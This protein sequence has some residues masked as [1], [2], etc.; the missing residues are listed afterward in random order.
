M[1]ITEIKL[2]NFRNYDEEIIELNKGINIFYGN[3]AQGK[4]NILES[5]FLCAMGKSFRSKKEKEL[6]KLDKNDA[7]I[8]I[9][10]N[11]SDRKGKIEYILSDKKQI[12]VNGIKINKLSELLGN[13]NIVMFSPD[14]IEILKGGPQKRRKFLNM[15]ISQLRPS[16]VYNYNL[17]MQ[18]LEQRNNYLRQIKNENKS[19]NMLDIWDEKLIEY[20]EIIYQYR[21]QFINKIK[22]KIEEIHYNI[23]DRKEKISIHYISDLKN[24][25]EFKNKLKNNRKQDIQ[26][27]YTTVGIHRDDFIVYI[28]KKELN[29]YGSQGQ[30]RTSILSLKLSELY[31]IYDEIG[32]YP[33]LLLDDFM[34]ELDESRRKKF[35]ENIT[36]TQVLITGTHKIILENFKYNIYNV[37]EGKIKKEE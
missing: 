3:N 29:I 23:T 27:G 14:D 34:S 8:E 33:I 7:K 35:I 19:E 22:E 21:N 4:T 1:N 28:N 30:F 6:I 2:K 37:K 31:T 11:K 17:Y 26:R 36:E 5:I 12:I 16:Y 24:I 20:A 18:T 9:E 10:Y 15:M 32:E 25:E 13:I